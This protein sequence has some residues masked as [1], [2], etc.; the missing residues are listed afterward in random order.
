MS[1]S[2]S[3][4]LLTAAV[5]VLAIGT[6]FRL[7][8]QRRDDLRLQ[9]RVAE[10][11][12]SAEECTRTLAVSEAAFADLDTRVDSLRD[13]TAVFESLDPAG[14]PAARYEE[15]LG[16]VDRYNAAVAD[17]EDSADSLRANETRCRATVQSYNTLVDSVRTAY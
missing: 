13:V 4:R 17:W 7:R 9:E 3:I 16:S 6:Q 1:R 15:Y 12:L 8:N 5:V 10:A 14:V 11:K 2:L